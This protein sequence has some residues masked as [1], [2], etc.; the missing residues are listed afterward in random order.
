MSEIPAAAKKSGDGQRFLTAETYT[1]QMCGQAQARRFVPGTDRIAG[2]V[3]SGATGRGYV[4]EVKHGSNSTNTFFVSQSRN[5]TF[6]L[7]GSKNS[8]EIFGGIIE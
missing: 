6:K 5:E 8:K 4:T 2:E 7:L 1:R 3:S